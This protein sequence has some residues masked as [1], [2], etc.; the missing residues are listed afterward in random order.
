MRAMAVTAYGEPLVEI[1]V[2]EPVVPHGYALLEVVT[3]G[4]C[5]S[6]VKV[7]RG[8]M[9]FSDTVALP[10]IPGH[11]IF[12][13]VLRTEP[14][15]LVEPGTRGTVFHSWSCGRCEACRR[16]DLALCDNLLG[17]VGFT[18]PG[19]FR[20]RIAVPVD[21]IIAIPPSI[22]PVHAAPM[23]CALGTAYRSVVVRGGVKASSTVAVIGLGGVGIHAAQIARAAGAWV[24][25]FDPHE[26][27][28]A[29][30]RELNLVA[31]PS[32]D[33]AVDDALREVGREGFD[34]VVDTVA[35]GETV[36]MANRLVRRGGR[37]VVVGYGP[38]SVVGVDTSRL[39]LDEIDVVG[40]RYA[41]LDDLERAVALVADD[42]V[43]TIVGLVAPLD[44]VNEVFAALEAGEVVGRAVLDVAGVA[45]PAP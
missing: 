41:H 42:R 32:D 11:E 28:R 19:G 18:T 15:G 25:G 36:A 16:G 7:S 30:A 35:H 24:V 26:A 38:R 44:R 1:D 9:P 43:R 14:E 23:S 33:D 13:R 34:V 5:F 6:D 21:R 29:A 10:H 8:L 12:G 3:C 2:A 22:D 37:I 39:V 20:E 31:R 27:T 4:V 17:W 45:G 40:S